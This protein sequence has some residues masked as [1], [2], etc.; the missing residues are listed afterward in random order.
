[1]VDAMATNANAGSSGAA[2]PKVR[3]VETGMEGH[4]Y[5]AQCK[6]TATITDADGSPHCSRHSKRV[7]QFRRSLWNGAHRDD[8]WTPYMAEQLREAIKRF[9]REF[10]VVA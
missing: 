1:M 8:K 9:Q 3:C 4:Y 2:P 6:R 10:P 5:A 7:Q